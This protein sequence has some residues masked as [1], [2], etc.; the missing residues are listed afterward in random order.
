MKKLQILIAAVALAVAAGGVGYAAIPAS[1]G[2]ITA[3]A[4]AKGVLRLIDAED[5]QTCRPGQQLL[6]WNQAGL[7][8]RTAAHAN[9]SYDSSD[10]KVVT[11]QCVEGQHVISGGGW[12]SFPYG[13][14]EQLMPGVGISMTRSEGNGWTVAAQEMIPTSNPWTLVVSALCADG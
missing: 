5:G 4:D 6:T 11:A 3:C 10:K 9:S 7:S 1:D 14:G 8:G 13:N 2:T 12:A